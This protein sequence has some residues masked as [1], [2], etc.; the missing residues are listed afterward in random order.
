MRFQ[1]A[2]LGSS[3]RAAMCAMILASLFFLFRATLCVS[4]P[5]EDAGSVLEASKADETFIMQEEHARVYGKSK[6]MCFESDI[7]R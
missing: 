3:L 2:R 4:A 7:Q 1:H 5:L 6:I